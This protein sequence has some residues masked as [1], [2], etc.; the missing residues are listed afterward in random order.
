MEGFQFWMET[1]DGEELRGKDVKGEVEEGEKK[2]T[3]VDY[4]DIQKKDVEWIGKI[5]LNDKQW[6][7]KKKKQEKR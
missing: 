2:K 5:L 7:E 6:L 3:G 1:P 4:E